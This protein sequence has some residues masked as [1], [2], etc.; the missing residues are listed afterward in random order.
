[1]NPPLG[2]DKALLHAR[3]LQHH[4]LTTGVVDFDA[5]CS[6]SISGFFAPK[7]GAMFGV[8]VA[9]DKEGNE[10]LL[11][12]FS[13]SCL[14][15]R[16]LPGWVDHLIDDET[17]LQ[18]ERT[19]D[20][21]IKELG[22][23]S[24]GKRESKELIHRRSELSRK[25]SLPITP[26]QVPTIQHEYISLFSC[27]PR[28]DTTGA[29]I[30]ARSS[31]G[32]R[33]LP[34]I[35]AGEH[36]RVLFGDATAT[37]TYHLDF[38]GPCDE[39]CN[40]PQADAWSGHHL[41][42][43][44]SGGGNKPAHLLSVPGR[45]AEHQDCIES[46]VRTLFPQ[47]PLQCAAHRL[48]MDT[49]GL[50]VLGLTKQAHRSLSMQFQ[51]QLVEKQYVALL[52]GVLTSEEGVIT[53]P[54]RLDVENRPR[55]IYDEHQGKW[56]TT[57]YKRLAVERLR[58]GKLVSRVL[59]TPHSGRT[60]Q[61]RLHSSHPKGLGIPILGDRLYGTGMDTRLHLHAHMLSFFH[62]KDGRKLCFTSNAP[63]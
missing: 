43:Q 35:A 34:P 1:M 41:P 31:A 17:F 56:G 2:E 55:Q 63:F 61:L 47:A 39:K 40:H 44:G 16:N 57:S 22:A 42:R 6:V 21:Q 48:D 33:L 36:G 30:A 20:P 25:P 58:S 52:E 60:H 3:V 15:R 29:E 45:G 13:G 24:S 28:K 32:V 59:F 27:F 12:A 9:I 54:F 4:L 46:R 7:G 5:D 14:G 37:K 23:P 11:K 62:P 8:L 10:V 26:V 19:F 50:L 38:Y 53:L 51:Q 49:S 18:Y